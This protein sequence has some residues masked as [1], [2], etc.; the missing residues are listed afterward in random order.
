MRAAAEELV[1]HA[2][3]VK[4]GD[5]VGEGTMAAQE[6]QVRG[7]T[8]AER[9]AF[10][11]RGFGDALDAEL[12]ESIKDAWV[13]NSH[14]LVSSLSFMAAGHE[15]LRT[16][17]QGEFAQGAIDVAGSDREHGIAGP[18][19]GEQTFDAFLQRGAINDVL[20]AGSANGLRPCRGG[21]GPETPVTGRG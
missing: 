8:D 18:D 5:Q 10:R 12:R 9:S 21:R 7:A 1:S 6:Q 14:Q 16:Q 4:Q 2:G 19:L 3:T 17:Q 11:E 15:M 20:V 13:T